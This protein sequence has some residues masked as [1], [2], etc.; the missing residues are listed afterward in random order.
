M[1]I[2]LYNLCGKNVA[3]FSYQSVT[4]VGEMTLPSKGYNNKILI[5]CIPS[6]LCTSQER[7]VHIRGA[8][9]EES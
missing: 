6:A 1:E 3:F 8:K 7:P 9:F 4:S 5:F 2:R